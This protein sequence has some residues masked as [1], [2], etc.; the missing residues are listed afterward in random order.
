M[1]VKIGKIVILNIFTFRI[2]FICL[3]IYFFIYDLY[4]DA[5]SSSDDTASN[6][7]VISKQ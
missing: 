5:V 4:K 7:G 1:N 3:F 2:L 6:V